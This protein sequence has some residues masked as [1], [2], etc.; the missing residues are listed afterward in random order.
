MKK[1]RWMIVLGSLITFPA[2]AFVGLLSQQVAVVV[3]SIALMLGS[4]VIS[5]TA[6]RGSSLQEAGF[7]SFFAGLVLLD[8]EDGL[9]QFRELSEAQ[10]KLL[11]ISAREYEVYSLELEE[12]NGLTG[13]LH[14]WVKARPEMTPMQIKESFEGNF[15]QLSSETQTVARKILDSSQFT[16]KNASQ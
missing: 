13:S 16:W 8:Q 6:P 9:I 10:Q 7:V 2:H 14:A 5:A 1:L 15:R 3:M 11:Q 4:S 12:L